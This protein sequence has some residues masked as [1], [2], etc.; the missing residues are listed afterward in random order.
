MQRL[1]A[2]WRMRYVGGERRPGCVFCNA[3]GAPD[4]PESLV[5]SAGE[6]AFMLLNRYPYNSGHLM[7]VPIEHVPTL[8]ALSSEARA[9]MFELTS[10][11]IEAAR[12]VFH[13]DG[14]NLGMNIGEVAGA[15]IADHLHMHLVPRWMGDANFMPIV[16]DT[17]VLPELLPV[18]H[19]RLRAEIETRLADKTGGQELVAGALVYL[20]DRQLFALRRS[21]GGKTVLPKGH[22]EDGETAAEAA[23]REVREETGIVATIA[24]W[25]GTQIIDEEIEGQQRNQ[26]VVMFL[27]TGEATVELTGH[28]ETD[29]V[30]VDRTSLV[31]SIDIP[32]LRSLVEAAL[33]SIDQLMGYS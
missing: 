18:T 21:R 15:G 4:D 13:C 17:M 8:E 10:L 29:V 33:P 19:A 28:L 7:I 9:E 12:P 26:H 30:L 5:L 32:T 22:I 31:E 3:L 6:H 16:A 25:L 2:P 23:I 1:W 24:G 20:P 11:A 14:F 27:A